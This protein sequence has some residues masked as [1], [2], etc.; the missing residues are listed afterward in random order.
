MSLVPTLL[1][2]RELQVVL[3]VDVQNYVRL[4]YESHHRATTNQQSSEFEDDDA[5]ALL[6][7]RHMQRLLWAMKTP[8]SCSIV[9]V[10]HLSPVSKEEVVSALKQT[11]RDWFDQRGVSFGDSSGEDVTVAVDS[12]ELFDDVITIHIQ[13]NPK[14]SHTPRLSDCNAPSKDSDAVHFS[15]SLTNP[16]VSDD[17]LRIKAGWPV[18]HRV[19]I[20]DR[21]CGEAVLRGSDIFVR[22][23]LCADAGIRQGEVVAVYADLSTSNQVKVTRGSVVEKYTGRCIFLGLGTAACNRSDFFR[24]QRGTAIQMAPLGRVGPILPPLPSV[25]G[26]LQNLPSIVVGHVL[27]P[28]RNDMILDMCTAPGGKALHLASLVHNQAIIVACDRSKRKILTAQ[29]LF[30]VE[31]ATCITPIAADSTRLLRREATT[32]AYRTVPEVS[33]TSHE[34]YSTDCFAAIHQKQI[35]TSA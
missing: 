27:S 32:G 21:F 34:S 30:A 4:S 12:H 1:S 24:L 16:A 23:I 19:V 17:V 2:Y 26:L 29:A 18:T 33:R 13:E 8:P 9:R 35:H 31:G 10:N 3:P 25:P 6:A 20:C 28:Q 5:A 22:G 7:E 15:A 14:R 11:V